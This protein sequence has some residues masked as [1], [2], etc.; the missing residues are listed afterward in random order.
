[1]LEQNCFT[2]QAS[3]MDPSAQT[4]GCLRTGSRASD[5]VGKWAHGRTFFLGIAK[6]PLTGRGITRRRGK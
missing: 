3:K 4:P 6:I 5:H 2:S 1:M